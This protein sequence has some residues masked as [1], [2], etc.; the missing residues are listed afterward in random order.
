M[1]SYL[2]DSKNDLKIKIDFLTKHCNIPAAD[3]EAFLDFDVIKECEEKTFDIEDF[4][5]AY[6]FGGIDLSRTTDLTAAS[7]IFIKPYDP[8]IYIVSHSFMSSE[9]Y[10]KNLHTD[11]VPYDV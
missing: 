10:E 1:E 8:T 2:Q 7:I 3:V 4:R 11:R 6:C 9:Q 5:G